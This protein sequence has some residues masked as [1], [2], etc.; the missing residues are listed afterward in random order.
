M[1]IKFLFH[2]TYV[3]RRAG[4]QCGTPSASSL[5]VSNRIA[6][7][8]VNQSKLNLTVGLLFLGILVMPVS[9]ANGQETADFFKQNCFSCHTIGGGRLTGPDLKDVESRKGRD[10]LV[11]FIVDPSGV[12]ASG[13]A[14]AKKLLAESNNVPMP[15]VAG[16]T[17]D[18]ANR[19]LNLIIAESKLTRSQFAGVDISGRALTDEDIKVGRALFTGEKR[20]TNGGPACTSCHGISGLSGLGGG[21]LGPDLSHAYSRLNGRK[22]MGAWLASPPTETMAPVYR[23]MPIDKEEILPLLAYLKDTAKDPAASASVG[24]IEFLVLGVIGAVVALLLCDVI[25]RR[26]FTGVRSKLAKGKR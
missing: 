3:F 4:G 16:M 2:L 15:K 17:Q 1:R 5:A 26:R 21:L 24:T 12:L 25:W 23:D 6:R 7:Y 11:R 14:Y 19:L 8:V 9:P 10:W 20:L 13:D 18:R 22:A